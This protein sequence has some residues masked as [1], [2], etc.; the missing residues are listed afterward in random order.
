MFRKEV[1]LE[2]A[3]RKYYLS[4]SELTLGAVKVPAVPAREELEYHTAEP[5]KAGREVTVID[6]DE[7][8]FRALLLCTF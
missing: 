4:F 7:V 8:Q 5:A 6:I 2:K 1:T 3:P